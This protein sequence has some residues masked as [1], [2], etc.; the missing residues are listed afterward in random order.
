MSSSPITSQYQAADAASSTFQPSISS[1]DSDYSD[2]Q[3]AVAQYQK[4][5]GTAGKSPSGSSGTP[6]TATPPFPNLS[7]AY[8]TSPDLIP[9]PNTSGSSSG[10]SPAPEPQFPVFIELATLM[11]TE[12]KFIGATQSL[13][14]DYENTLKPLVQGAMNSSTLFGQ[15]VGE[16]T[17]VSP[18]SKAGEI[19]PS[20]KS[21]PLDQEGTKFAAAIN[22]QM[23]KLLQSIGQVIEAF[24]VFTARI[25]KAGQYYTDAD[26]QSAFPP[27]GLMEG[28]NVTGLGG[29]S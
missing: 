29:G 14:S 9:L 7:M 25:N 3:K 8:T 4:T 21:D 23:G 17:G 19:Y 12:G 15:N 26:A 13:V 10:G 27:P 5:Y 22:P 2:E 24:G 1:S 6:L 16:S 11:T 20:Y 28:P 18:T